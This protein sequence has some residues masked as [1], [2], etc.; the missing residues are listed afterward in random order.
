MASFIKSIK[1]LFPILIFS[2][3]ISCDPHGGYEYWIENQ[4]DSSLFVEYSYNDNDSVK[5]QIVTPGSSFLVL[6]FVT[7]NGLY[8][9][10][11]EDLYYFCDSLYIMNDTIS[12]SK[13]G[14]DYSDRNNW[15]YEQE[16]TSKLMGAGNNIYRLII[17][18]EDL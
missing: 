3:F 9:S 14:L 6:E 11:L 10:G 16:E 1:Y 8:D 7:H 13:I 12:R 5:I 4:S 18:P 15:I 2:I 17:K